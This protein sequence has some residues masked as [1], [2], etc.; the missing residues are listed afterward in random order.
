[1]TKRLQR[2]KTVAPSITNWH[3]AGATLK[4]IQEVC[5]AFIRG[6]QPEKVD[7]LTVDEVKEHFDTACAIVEFCMA[8][9]AKRT[10]GLEFRDHET[11]RYAR[12]Y[13][14]NLAYILLR[15]KSTDPRD[16]WVYEEW[17]EGEPDRPIITVQY[18]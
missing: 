1:M 17:L 15:H 10:T 12:T 8:S 18:I 14:K 13:A 4:Q 7:H 9:I 5:E 2:G 16:L 3:A 6:D 11:Y